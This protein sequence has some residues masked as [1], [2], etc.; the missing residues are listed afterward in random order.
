MYCIFIEIAL[1]HGCSP[2]YLLH[3]FK[4]LFNKKTSGGLLLSKIFSSG[5]LEAWNRCLKFFLLLKRFIILLKADKLFTSNVLLKYFAVKCLLIF[6]IYLYFET[7]LDMFQWW[8]VKN[9]RTNN[10][11]DCFFPF[12]KLSI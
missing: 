2:V 6:L 1:Q 3:I 5:T 10:T 8:K 11:C 7:L 9:L 4:T 12:P